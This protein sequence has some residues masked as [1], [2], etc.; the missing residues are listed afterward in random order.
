MLNYRKLVLFGFVFLVCSVSVQAAT[1]SVQK[2]GSGDFVEIIPAVEAASPGDT[3][4]IGPGRF[5]TFVEFS[6]PYWSTDVIIPVTKDNLTFVGSGP[7][8]TFIGPESSNWELDEDPMGFISIDG[9]SGIIKDMTIENVETGVYWYEGNLS[10]DNCLFN[11]ERGTSCA[12]AGWINQLLVNNCSFE[13]DSLS[14]GVVTWMPTNKVVISN[15]LFSGNGVGCILM[16]V[17]D[18]EVTSCRFDSIAVGV[19]YEDGTRGT[20]SDCEF[21]E[22]SYGAIVIRDNVDCSASNLTITDCYRGVKA[23]NGSEFLGVLIDVQNSTEYGFDIGAAS[24][25]VLRDSHIIPASGY[26]VRVHT[27][28][29]DLIEQDFT[30]N[31]WGTTDP[32]EVAE[33]IWDI[34]DDP[35]MNSIVNYLPMADGPLATEDISLDGL[36]AMFR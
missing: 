27:V 29:V 21:T 19:N 12:I 7:G 4:F 2:D 17:P 5:E 8:V 24:R 34:N 28:Y 33:M 10:F 11:N 6:T 26:A 16:G 35:T 15:C 3:I 1:W 36:K 13:L 32:A 30:G 9:Y 25:M 20:V 31:Y 18:A 23:T 22:A 14:N